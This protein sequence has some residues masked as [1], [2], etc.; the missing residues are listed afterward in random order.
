MSH[1]AGYRFRAQEESFCLYGW[2]AS[3][4]G[5]MQG[6]AAFSTGMWHR[7]CENL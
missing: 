5:L 2:H 1:V 3:R 6:S 7:A 4:L